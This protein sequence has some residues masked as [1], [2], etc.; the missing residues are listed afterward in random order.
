MSGNLCC[1]SNQKLFHP[2]TLNDVLFERFFRIT[3]TSSLIFHIRSLSSSVIYRQWC[4]NNCF[5]Y[6]VTSTL[7]IAQIA[8][9]RLWNI[10]ISFLFNLLLRHWHS[11]ENKIQ[12]NFHRSGITG[13][14][15]KKIGKRGYF[16]LLL[17][18]L[19]WVSFIDFS[20]SLEE[21]SGRGVYNF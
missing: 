10:P 20:S 1:E 15:R 19:P 11:G 17:L 3:Q 6:F 8:K 13:L 12:A 4:L 14:W 18:L 9:A 7:K 21:N 16:Q 5:Q 2:L